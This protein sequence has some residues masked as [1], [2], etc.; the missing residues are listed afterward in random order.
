MITSIFVEIFD[1]PMI[2]VIGFFI[3]EVTFFN[4]F[5][6]VSNCRP[7]K[8]GINSVILQ[9]EACDLWEQENASLT[10]K[11]PSFAKCFEKSK[12]FFSSST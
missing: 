6:S 4:A 10:N 2:Q 7:A 11:S 8:D 3:S 1:P 5:N 12:S 9:T